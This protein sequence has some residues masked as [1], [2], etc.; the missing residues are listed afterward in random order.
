MSNALKNAYL[1]IILPYEIYLAKH[2]QVSTAASSPNA[3]AGTKRE[4][5]TDASMDESQDTL[6]TPAAS[7]PSIDNLIP[8]PARRSKRV[9]KEPISYAGTKPF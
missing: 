1:N 7:P 5:S 6:A 8:T 2:R 9:K 4:A 3:T